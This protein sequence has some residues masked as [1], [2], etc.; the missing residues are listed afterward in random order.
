MKT[1][2]ITGITG[3]LGSALAHYYTQ[4]G[5]KV[6]G[7]VRAT[8]S[9]KRIEDILSKLEICQINK[10]DDVADSVARLEPHYIIHTACAYG[11]AGESLTDI[12]DS[13][14]RLGLL[15]LDAAKRIDKRVTFLNT[16]TV[17]DKETNTYSMSKIFFSDIGAMQTKQEGNK[18]QFI[19]IALQHMYGPGDDISKFTTYVI[20]SC[21]T[22][23]QKIDLTAGTQ[24]RDFIYLD[25]TVS[26]Y[27]AII[28]NSEKLG[29]TEEIEVGSGQAVQVRE[30]AELTHKICASSTKLNFGKIPYRDGESM[31]YEADTTKLRSLGWMPNYSLKEGLKKTVEKETVQ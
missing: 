28:K 11:R 13:N 23:V 21:L 25:D 15:L 3:F 7:L 16:G 20:K 6:A 31:H 2:L 27:D 19:N 14:V 4:A 1:I 30:F 26:A 10:D 29:S 12:Y 24:K 22:N 9:Y 8:S 17:L 18:L 5:Y